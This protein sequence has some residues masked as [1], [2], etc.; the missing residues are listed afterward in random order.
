MGKTEAYQPR[1]LAYC[2]A[3]GG[4]SPRETW[5]RDGERYPGGKGAGFI[6][7]IQARVRDWRAETGYIGAML[8]HHHAAFDAWLDSQT[9][10]CD[11]HGQTLLD[12]E[13]PH[14]D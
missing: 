12:L 5:D 10:P 8:N 9:V 13:T 1:Y 14:A 3:T 4:L 11:T 2:R 7:W 6:L